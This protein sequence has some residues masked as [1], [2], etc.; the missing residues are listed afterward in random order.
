MVKDY[1]KTAVMLE[2]TIRVGAI[3]CEKNEDIC[4]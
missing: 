3:N 4:R 2:G 1:K